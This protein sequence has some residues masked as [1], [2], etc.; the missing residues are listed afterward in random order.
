M[1]DYLRLQDRHSTALQPSAELRAGTNGF[2]N[3]PAEFFVQATLQKN[4]MVVFS[5]STCPHCMA[6]KSVLDRYR[7]K[8]GLEYLV[9]EVDRRKDAGDIKRALNGLYQRTT[10][11]SVFIDSQCI[12]GNDDIQRLERLD[13]L[14]QVL[15]KKGLLKGD[16]EDVAY[17]TI[18]DTIR[19]YQVAMFTVKGA[20]DRETSGLLEKFAAKHSLNYTVIRIDERPNFLALRQR[21]F[22][23]SGKDDFP[24][25]YIGR[26]AWGGSPS[27]IPHFMKDGA[28][29]QRMEYMGLAKSPAAEDAQKTRASTRNEQL[30]EF[31]EAASLAGSRFV[32]EFIARFDVAVFGRASCTYSKALESLLK[33][34]TRLYGLQYH[35]VDVDQRSDSE[36]IK[37]ELLRISGLNTF[38][39][40]FVKRRSLGGNDSVYAK[41]A[42]GELQGLLEQSGLLDT[43]KVES[44]KRVIFGHVQRQIKD[45]H[46]V[47][48]GKSF[49]HETLLAVRLFQN[50]KDRYNVKYVFEKI[51]RH[52]DH[53][54]FSSAV[55]KL[56]GHAGLPA[57]FV[58]GKEVGGFGGLQKLYNTGELKSMLV[59]SQ[60]IEAGAEQED[61]AVHPPPAGAAPV[62][63]PVERRIRQ[64]IKRNRVMVFSKT[65][66]PY[67]RRAKALL[68]WYKTDGGLEF[69]V[70]EADLE[71][72][73]LAVKT[74]LSRI[75]GRATFPNVFVDGKSIGG[76]DDIQ[77][78]H[79]SGELAALLQ[80]KSLIR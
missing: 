51:D 47:V 10:F 45:S 71:S 61:V 26:L 37:A 7:M 58:G 76:S 38:P 34:Y 74:A 69:A 66:C 21:L 6:T 50:Y 62:Q 23:I 46:L 40:M 11:P 63:A 19:K 30:P 43:Q 78:M 32:Q 35:W 16:V 60:L 77:A 25:T 27:D 55:A 65:Y 44:Q 29:E 59:K 2:A 13:S 17:R 20:D 33:D 54:Q 15:A 9:I 14:A 5:K 72:D 53:Q 31:A 8:H 49:D 41:H 64:L 70:L 73:P 75:S 18:M 24:I 12:G 36:Q 3:D 42:S 28:I 52:V 80:K 68:S 56:A 67:S 4:R 1:M 39:N 22:R 79:A 48:Y 57:V